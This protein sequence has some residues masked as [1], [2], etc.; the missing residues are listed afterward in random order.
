M[1]FLFPA[2]LLYF[3]VGIYFQIVFYRKRKRVFISLVIFVIFIF[4]PI[5]D[6]LYQEFVYA[7]AK[8]VYPMKVINKVVNTSGFK[9]VGS[10]CTPLAPTFKTRR[11][12]D[13]K[14]KLVFEKYDNFDINQICIDCKTD[15]SDVGYNSEKNIVVMTK[16]KKFMNIVYMDKIVYDL[17]QCELIGEYRCVAMMSSF[18]FFACLH[19]RSS[20]VG[21]M[22]PGR[23]EFC[24]FEYEVL[25]PYECD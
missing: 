5:V 15:F 24:Y 3:L 18:P 19:G 11:I 20:A 21:D 25:T 8:N 22:Y 7:N 6:T 2:V 13:K 23:D 12:Q 9:V 14:F 16:E 10:R 4:A 17:H 1:I